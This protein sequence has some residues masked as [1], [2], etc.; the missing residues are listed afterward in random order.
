MVR[1]SASACY[2]KSRKLAPPPPHTHTYTKRT[3][4]WGR[5]GRA[6]QEIDSKPKNRFDTD[7][8]FLFLSSEPPNLPTFLLQGGGG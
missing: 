5:F 4:Y 1:A 8:R 2:A 6:Q 3:P 7:Q